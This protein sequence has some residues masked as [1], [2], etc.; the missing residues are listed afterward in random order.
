MYYFLSIG[1]LSVKVDGVNRIEILVLKYLELKG[2][3]CS[4]SAQFFSDSFDMY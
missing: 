1:G 3:L 4:L 2:R